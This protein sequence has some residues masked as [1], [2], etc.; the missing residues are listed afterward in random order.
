MRNLNT[1]LSVVR[2]LNPLIERIEPRVTQFS[3]HDAALSW[4]LM[5]IKA[6]QVMKAFGFS[7]SNDTE[8]FILAKMRWKR[9]MKA[10][11]EDEQR[12]ER[13]EEKQGE[14]GFVSRG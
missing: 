9:V 5:G 6:H 11:K 4:K 7:L 1:G 13:L 14:V 12:T 8:R 3:E 10:V 2:V